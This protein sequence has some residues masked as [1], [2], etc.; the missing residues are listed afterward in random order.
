MFNAETRPEY[1]LNKCDASDQF[2]F[3]CWMDD[4]NKRARTEFLIPN[5]FISIE[6]AGSYSGD[7]LTTPTL[8]VQTHGCGTKPPDAA[9]NPDTFAWNQ[10]QNKDWKGLSEPW[11]LFPLFVLHAPRNTQ[12]EWD[13]L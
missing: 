3:H 4:G 7:A 11:P 12:R 13:G 2:R 6:A 10:L 8:A 5:V 1:E 9:T